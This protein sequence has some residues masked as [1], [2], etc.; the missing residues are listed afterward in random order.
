MNALNQ[1]LAAVK[2][3]ANVFHNGKYCGIWAVDTSGTRNITFHVVS[4]GSCY[5]TVQDQSFKLNTGDVV[6]FPSDV[7]HHISHDENSDI[8][9]NQAVSLPMTADV[10]NSTGL[11]CG[12]LEHQH[13]VFNKLLQQLPSWIIVR[14]DQQSAS[15]EIIGL[16]LRESA[17]SGQSTNLLLNRLSDCLFYLLLRDHLDA[18]HGVLRALAHPKLGKS[19]E[20]IHQQLEEKLSL[21]ELASQAGMSRSAFSALFKQVVGQSPLEYLTQWRMTQAYRW[22]ADDG[23]STFEAALR[24]GYESEASF[25]KAFKRV[26]SIGPGQARTDHK[27]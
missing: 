8:P 21:E 22:L 7:Q 24:C 25:S 11:V 2:V 4:Q 26:M 5:L 1:L 15:S 9:V 12:Y 3:E 18:D 13:P 27:L 20:L 10:D 14:R 17:E 23:I 19:L 6:F 16:M